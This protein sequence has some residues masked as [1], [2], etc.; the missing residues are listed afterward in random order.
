MNQ[1]QLEPRENKKHVQSPSH[2]QVEPFGMTI[3]HQVPLRTRHQV[4]CFPR[5]DTRILPDNPL[6]GHGQKSPEIRQ[7]QRSDPPLVLRLRPRPQRPLALLLPHILEPEATEPLHVFAGRAV[8]QTLHRPAPL[9]HLTPPNETGRRVIAG[10]ILSAERVAD[11]QQLQ[12]AA[13]LKVV[14]AAGQERGPVVDAGGEHAAV[15]EA[16]LACKVP[17]LVCVCLQKRDVWWRRTIRGRQVR[18]RDLGGGALFGDGEGPCAGPAADVEDGVDVS[19]EGSGVETAVQ[20]EEP[21]LMLEIWV[22]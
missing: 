1:P 22:I 16:E 19:W 14:P 12:P 5:T 13:G 20:G 18:G 6:T 8:I 10:G 7:R 11:I 17:I 9:R 2:S 15:D 4:P 3:L 21:D